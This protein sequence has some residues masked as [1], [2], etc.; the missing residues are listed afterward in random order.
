M[1]GRWR[2]DGFSLIEMVLII[3][4]TG[5]LLPFIISPYITSVSGIGRATSSAAISYVARGHLE[6]E[7]YAV[8]TLWPSPGGYP[9][10]AVAEIVGGAAYS[11]VIDAVFVDS[12]FAPTDGAPGNDNFLWITATTTNL[13]TGSSVALSMLK[14]RVYN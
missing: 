7:S 14:S 9:K 3:L 13:S 10:Q 1:T 11:T 6:N 2:D 12:A 5:I 8:D 4:M